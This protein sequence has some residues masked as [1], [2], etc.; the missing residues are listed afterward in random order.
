MDA[1]WNELSALSPSAR[2]HRLARG[3]VDPSTLLKHDEQRASYSRRAQERAREYREMKA[4]L[5][6]MSPEQRAAYSRHARKH[7]RECITRS[8]RM[9]PEQRA[10]YSQSARKHAREYMTRLTR[11]SPEQRATHSRRVHKRALRRRELPN[12]VPAPTITLRFRDVQQVVD[13][14]KSLVV[15]AE[16]IT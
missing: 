3:I 4:H 15:A 8:T 7:A 14:T 9:S 10:A 11:R 2:R 12:F 1:F 13:T 5:V 16:L 6:R